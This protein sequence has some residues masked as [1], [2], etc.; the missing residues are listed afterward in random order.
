MSE[1]AEGGD[2][3][4]QPATGFDRYRSLLDPTL[5]ILVPTDEVPPFR[6]KA[7]GWELLQSSIEVGAAIEARIADKGFFLF[8]VNEDQSDGVELSEPPTPDQR[9]VRHET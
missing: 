1:S 2:T 5:T 3:E 4:S 6:F 8:R 7:G 9:A